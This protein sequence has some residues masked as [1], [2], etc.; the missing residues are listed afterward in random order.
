MLFEKALPKPVTNWNITSDSFIWQEESTV[1][2]VFLIKLFP[3]EEKE[4]Q[5]FQFNL[6]ASKIEG[7]IGVKYD[8]D[9]GCITIPGEKMTLKDR[10]TASLLELS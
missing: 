9:K 6:P 3:N 2:T 1:P 4:P 10:R 5:I 7:Q 8:D